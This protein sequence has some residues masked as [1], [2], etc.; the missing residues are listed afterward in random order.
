MPDD[1]DTGYE[2]IE[3]PEDEPSA[4]DIHDETPEPSTETAH[5]N[6]GLSKDERMWG[7]ACHL[8]GAAIVTC[9]PFINVLAPFAVCMLKRGEYPFVDTEGKESVNFQITIAIAMV[10]AFML[11]LLLRWFV[12]LLLAIITI[13]VVFVV[14]ASMTASEGKSY[15]YPLPFRFVK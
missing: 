4:G 14:I 13:D 5:T 12:L 2:P 6:P 1:V 10:T 9:I 3:L 8:S 7:M 15:R 11:T